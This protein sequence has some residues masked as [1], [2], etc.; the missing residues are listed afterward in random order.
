[1]HPLAGPP[2]KTN[3]YRFRDFELEPGERRLAQQGRLIALTPKV[4]DTLV[5]LVERAG[6]VVTK[7]E[8]MQA[9]W[10]RGYVEESNLTKHIWVIRRAL[11]E[12]EAEASAI[13]TVPKT[14]YRFVAPVTV[15]TPPL[16]AAP[17]PAPSPT[18]AAPASLTPLPVPAGTPREGPGIADP[19]PGAGS[20]RRSDKLKAPQLFVA[21]GIAGA[22]IAGGILLVRQVADSSPAAH[23]AAVLGFSNLSGNAKDAWV[24]PA[25]TEM[26][27]AEL[28]SARPLDVVPDELVRSVSLDLPPPSA[29]GYSPA[30]LEQLRRRL[31]VD[32]VISGSYLVGSS[33]EDAPLR[34]DLI[35]QDARSH[36][37][38]ATLS[39]NSDVNGVIALAAEAGSTVL[40]KLGVR[41]R[42]E[43]TQGRLANLKPPSIDV[44]RRVGFALDAL[45]RYDPA[46]ARDELLE[47]VAEAPGYA[48]AYTLLAQAWG[49]L[50]YRDKALAA[51]EQ[52]AAKSTA[53]PAEPRLEAQA[54]VSAARSDWRQAAHDWS[55]LVS[56]RP[57]DV[58][59][60]L[61]AVDA[62]IAAGTQA[63]AQAS[64]A[65][66]QKLA[67]S[68]PRVDLAA[69]RLASAFD[70]ARGSAQWSASALSHAQQR[71]AR[72]LV[73]DAQVALAGARMHLNQNE[74]ARASLLQA[75]DTYRGI[76]NPRG[77]ATARTKLAQVL[78][79]LNHIPEAREEYQRAMA[80]DQA[81]GDLNGQASIYRNLSEMLWTAGDRDGAQAA[82]RH[83]L[84]I[85]RETGDTA[86]QSWTLQALAVIQ[87]DD[88]ASD[89]VLDE[90][91]EVV[92]LNQTSGHQTVWPLTNVA[93][94]QRMRGELDAARTTCDQAQAQAASLGD[95][96]F[97]V[98]STFTCGMIAADQGDAAQARARFNEAIR[99]AAT[100]G[101][102]LY[103]WNSQMML[104]QLDLDEGRWSEACGRLRK[105]ADAFAAAEERTGEAD[106]S[107][108]LAQCEQAR[109]D[110]QASH[111]AL[112]HAADLRRAM[113]SRQEVYQ[114]DIVAARLSA[115]HAEAVKQLLRLAND[116]EQRHFLGWSLEARLAAWQVSVENGL[117]QPAGLHD[118]L[119]ASAR[120]HGYGRI[121]RLLEQP[122][123]RVHAA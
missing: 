78:A 112:A 73:A 83:A 108:L 71:D 81:I 119:E 103:A 67:P 6:H 43:D 68:D 122:P 9:L 72:G 75:I 31:K 34:V 87:S 33:A 28:D 7:D 80:L 113:T 29:G 84:G 115:T 76:R 39:R 47:A 53:L 63:E 57:N 99:R 89:E 105:V 8:L 101:V 100:G 86:M 70:D 16:P 19:V 18:T 90:F 59:Y 52:A 48:P 94:V 79:S 32:Y 69:A 56:L 118:Q 44:A 62:A 1:M 4:F 54:V 55:A 98:F 17:A 38:L 92:N 22:L 88:S 120:Q 114:V 45:E 61:H 30:T 85:G 106:A 58:D 24:G 40:D 35:L 15:V 121:L 50:G 74:A 64:V 95:P 107:A 11:G 66:L 96:Q 2:L 3:I 41:P 123:A 110:A 5:L 77:E 82:A 25:L 60:R 23:T 26:V 91:R 36:A 13:E 65:A 51:A 117:A 37:A 14:G 27:E 102:D 10:P 93:D 21:L 49:A 116:A 12:R 46:R 109:G 97:I 42:G 20:Q 104:A 111:A